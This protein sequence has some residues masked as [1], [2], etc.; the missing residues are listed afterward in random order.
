M[1]FVALIIAITIIIIAKWKVGSSGNKWKII[2]NKNLLELS[3]KENS[4]NASEVKSLLI[5]IDKLLDFVLKSKGIK[6]EN[7]GGRLK[8]ASKLFSK[9]DYQ[10]IWDAHKARNVL[11][12]EINP[13]ISTSQILSHYKDIRK[14]I[15]KFCSG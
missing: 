3:K 6:G 14:G 10:K 8:N 5:E 15:E 9:N 11:A 1:S 13:K 12:H 2:V 7:M 4:Q